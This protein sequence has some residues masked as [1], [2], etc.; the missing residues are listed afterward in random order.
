MA[1]KT[2]GSSGL[3]YIERR[4]SSPLLERSG[5]ERVGSVA[6]DVF[7]LDPG[8]RRE[9]IAGVFFAVNLEEC[10]PVIATLSVRSDACAFALRTNPSVAT[11]PDTPSAAV[12]PTVCRKRRLLLLMCSM[13]APLQVMDDEARF[14]LRCCTPAA[15]CR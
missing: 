5:G 4:A 3:P 9:N 7:A 15:C 12:A 2:S 13:I 8:L 14:K 11:P 1:S 10:A 6:A